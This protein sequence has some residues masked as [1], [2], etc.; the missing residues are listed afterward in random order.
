MACHIRAVQNSVQV[1]AG[2]V[3]ILSSGN[4]SEKHHMACSIRAV[5]NSVQVIA[6]CVVI[7]SSGNSSEKYHMETHLCGRLETEWMKYIVI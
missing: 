1:I 5:R 2:C 4:S 3:V 6:G 7:L